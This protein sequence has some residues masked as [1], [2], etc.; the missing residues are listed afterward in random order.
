[1]RGLD[2]NILV[3]LLLRDDRQQ[4]ELARRT[5]ERALAAGE[6]LI[7]G[8]M[9]FLETE[10]ALRSHTGLRKAEVILL[11]K[12]LLEARDV[13]FENE[14]VIEQALY[15]YKNGGADF[16]D[17]LLIAQYLHLGCETMLTF[18]VRASRVLGGEFLKA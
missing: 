3:R 15:S 2:T 1:M 4:S 9:A 18:D 17:C 5:I 10:W 8:T 12:Q 14:G 16:A 11:F 6:P 7:V 13:V